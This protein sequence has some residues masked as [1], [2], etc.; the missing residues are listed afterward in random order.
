MKLFVCIGFKFSIVSLVFRRVHK[1]AKSDYWL[2]HFRPSVRLS[3]WNISV[4]TGQSFKILDIRVFFQNVSRKFYFQEILTRT[5]GTLHED[6]CTSMIIFR[7]G[8]VRTRNA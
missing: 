6:L 3:T 1:L 8:L 2:R 5:M 4:P 7:S